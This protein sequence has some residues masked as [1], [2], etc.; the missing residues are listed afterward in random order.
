[1]RVSAVGMRKG[2]VALLFLAAAAWWCAPSPVWAQAAEL[3]PRAFARDV[4]QLE[5]DQLAAIDRGD[6]VTRLLATTDGAEIAAF[7]VV[8][9]AGTLDLLLRLSKDV[10]RSRQVSHIPEIGLFSSPPRLGDLDLLQVPPEDVKALRKCS[11]GSC[12][13]KLGPKALDELA[14]I[15]WASRGADSEVVAV[16][17]RMMLEFLVAYQE[18][19]T[20]SLDAIADKST[21]KSRTQEYQELLAHSP[22][23]V[24]YVKEFHHYLAVYPEGTLPQ[25]EDLFYWTKEEFGLKPVI[26]LYHLTVHREGDHIL[27]ANKLLAASHYFNASLEILAGV[28]TADGKGLY[29]FSLQRTRIDPPTGKL[30]GI[31]IEKVRS[32]LEA[33]VRERLEPMRARL[34]E[35]AAETEGQ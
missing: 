30:A 29:L 18:G 12:D 27:V 3:D 31:Q 21:V 11:P 9:A 19:G 35:A 33:G 7:G 23:L 6:V 13:V 28:P 32:G 25:T 24:E 2:W 17:K 4:L 14:R 5:D 20:D 26:S 15:D 10:K 1:M 34:A 16:I 8:R 22:Y